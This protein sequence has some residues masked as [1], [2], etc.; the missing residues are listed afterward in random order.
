M[1]SEKIGVGYSYC[2]SK[3][4]EEG[5]QIE[6]IYA[7][8]TKAFD[9]FPHCRLRSYGVNDQLILW[10]KDFLLHRSQTVKINNEFSAWYCVISDIPQGVLGPLLFVITGCAV[11]QHCYNGD[12]SFLWGKW[13]L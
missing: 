12:V 4:L 10:I 5:G 7:D 9:K 8:F 11:A 3:K 13:K 1:G 2:H 6:A